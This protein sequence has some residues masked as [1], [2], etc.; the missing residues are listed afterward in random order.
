[1]FIIIVLCLPA[2]A[3]CQDIAGLWK[4]TMYNDSTKQSLS[5]EIIILNEKGKFSGFSHTWFIINNQKYFGVK[6][7]KIN[8]AKDGKIVIQD[9]ELLSNNYPDGPDK[10]V[11]QLNV[12]DLSNDGKDAL[13][14]GPFATNR[15]KKY[16]ELTGQ[17]NIKKVGD[18]N[19]S[20]VMPHLEKNNKKGNPVVKK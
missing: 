12:L 4:G 7:V 17:I 9:E 5:Y 1:M 3:F 6:K 13:L 16:A 10:N 2:I 14:R 18:F 11:R 19:N 15:T 8:I 20:E